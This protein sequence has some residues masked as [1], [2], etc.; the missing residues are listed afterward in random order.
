[1][2]ESQ[3]KDPAISNL[4]SG[5]LFDTAHIDEEFQKEQEAREKFMAAL[6][7]AHERGED[8]SEYVWPYEW[9][10]RKRPKPHHAFNII[11]LADAIDLCGGHFH[12]SGWGARDW[13]ARSPEEIEL[14]N[15]EH[16]FYRAWNFAENKKG[17]DFTNRAEEEKQAFVRKQ[18]IYSK[19]SAWLDQGIIESFTLDNEGNKGGISGNVWLSRDALE[20]L[21]RG[22]ITEKE[23]GKT[24]IGGK[25][26]FVYLNKE[27]LVKILNTEKAPSET[28]KR[29][30]VKPEG[31][32]CPEGIWTQEAYC[33]LAEKEGNLDRKIGWLSQRLIETLVA[34]PNIEIFTIDS[35]TGKKEDFHRD[36]LRG[37]KAVEWFSIGLIKD[38]PGHGQYIFVNRIQFENFLADRPVAE[39]PE[40][41]EG[42]EQ[43]VA[44]YV[45]AYLELMLKAAKALN[46]SADKR[47]NMDDIVGW[48]NGNWPSGL[49]GKS[50]RM[51]QS[52][53]TLLRRPQDKK[54]GNT[55]WSKE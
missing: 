27:Q 32:T 45:P 26:N 33:S 4:L 21:D 19:L 11:S 50:D 37:K 40:P 5:G 42:K 13:Y 18:E 14:W 2:P 16:N 28:K 36:F 23:G 51:V 3:K 39:S 24:K 31:I 17:A 22:E 7:K 54:G 29:K 35:Y 15:P 30:E 47:A 12:G 25:S 20:I 9:D 8:I 44:S 48:L 1:M 38:G 49:E 52:M 10:F 55:R 34:E 43:A 53:A 6:K 46:L 41:D